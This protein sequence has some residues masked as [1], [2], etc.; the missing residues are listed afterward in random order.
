MPDVGPHPHAAL[1]D[2]ATPIQNIKSLIP[3]MLDLS[4][5]NFTKWRNLLSIAVNLLSLTDNLE[6]LVRPPDKEWLRMDSMV[7]RWLYSSIMPN[8]ADMVMA[9]GTTVFPITI[10]SPTSP[11]TISRRMQAS[12]ARS[13]K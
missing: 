5:S 12:S 4:A 9:G 10:A 1:W 13:S 3:V 7:P 11:V 6:L 2:T 8:I